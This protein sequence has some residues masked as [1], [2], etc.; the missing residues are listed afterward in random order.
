MG[1]S[2]RPAHDRSGIKHNLLAISTMAAFWH[3]DRHDGHANL[4]SVGNAASNLIDD[5]RRLHSWHVRR[6]ISLLLFGARAVADPDV[7]WVDRR[8]MDAEPHLSWAGVNF[9]QYND[10]ENLRTAMSE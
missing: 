6:R 5:A 7:G 4:E 2:G 8:C 3:H 1:L 9:R 10:L